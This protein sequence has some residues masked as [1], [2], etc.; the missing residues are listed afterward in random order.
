MRLKVLLYKSLIATHS[1][2][3]L[4]NVTT[5]R[6]QIT[7]NIR[8]WNEKLAAEEKSLETIQDERDT[9]AETLQVLF[10]IYNTDL[11]KIL[12]GATA[13]CPVRV[14]NDEIKLGVKQIEA[15]ID[16]LKK[17]MERMREQ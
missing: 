15:K 11:Q 9:E 13:Y 16:A 7:T 6:M 17:Q 10:N 1:K 5:A 3:E 8:H 14:P 2:D 4:K 12:E